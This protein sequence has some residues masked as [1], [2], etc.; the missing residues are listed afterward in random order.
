MP[1]VELT[2]LKLSSWRKIA[3]GSWDNPG[4][5]SVYGT[6]EINATKILEGQKRWTDA[7]PGKKPPTLTAIV[8]RAVAIVLH[9]HPQINGLIRFGRIY[10]RKHVSLFLQTAVDD[11]GKELSGVVIHEAEKKSLFEIFDELH[12]KARAI[13]QDK[14]PNF[15]KVKSNFKVMPAFLMRFVLN[16]MSFLL[17]TLN[18]DLRWAGLPADPFG[19]VMITSIGSLGLDEAFGPLVRYSRVPLL[20]AVG[21]VRERAV[22]ENGAIKIAPIFKICVTFDHRFVDGVH[23][24]K[25]VR[26]LRRLIETDEG[27]SELGLR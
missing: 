24:A 23:G 21:A 15:K 8:A 16:T 17:Y 14:D 27:L 25:M 9:Q 11:E 1:N 6:L 26:A 13:R 4:D 20:L 22:V 2:P 7:N 5:P 12:A 10:S 19:S 18:L 3:L